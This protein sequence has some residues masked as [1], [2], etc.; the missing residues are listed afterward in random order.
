MLL[1]KTITTILFP[2]KIYGDV[3]LFILLSYVCLPHQNSTE[4]TNICRKLMESWCCI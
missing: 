1:K 3:F 2:T 4:I